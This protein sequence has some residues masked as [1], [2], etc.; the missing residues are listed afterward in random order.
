MAELREAFEMDQDPLHSPPKGRKY[1]SESV[2][3]LLK[4]FFRMLP[5]PAFPLKLYTTFIKVHEAKGR[6]GWRW[7]RVA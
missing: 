7:S 6:S 1:T 4:L 3:G 5:N 2:G